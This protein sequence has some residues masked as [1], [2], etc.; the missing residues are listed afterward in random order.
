[1]QCER[2]ISA[3]A[4]NRGVTRITEMR[5]KVRALQEQGVKIHDFTVGDSLVRM[6]AFIREQE[7]RA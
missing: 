3:R 6:P 7:V 1:M 5:R 2:L 4:G